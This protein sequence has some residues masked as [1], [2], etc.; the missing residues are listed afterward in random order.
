[1][2]DTSPSPEPTPP[3]KRGRTIAA[4]LAVILAAPLLLAAGWYYTR[5]SADQEALAEQAVHAEAAFAPTL[6]KLDEGITAAA[7]PDAPAYDIDKTIRVIHEIDQAV[8]NVDDLE[9]WLAQAS[10]QDYRGVAP[11][12]LEARRELL[13]VL[14]R[15]YA[16]QV[17]LDDQA[18][19]WDF[20]SGLV[21][22]SAMSVVEVEGDLNLMA[23]TGSLSVDQAKAEELLDK[24]LASQ[25]EQAR[26]Q[27]EL[28]AVEAELTRAMVQYSD[29][30][31]R[32]LEE[33][34][35]VNLAR[36]R[37]YLAAWSGSWDM[38]QEAS[39]EAI[40][41]AP[42]EREAHLLLA[43][44]LIEGGGG[45][46]D[47]EAERLLGDYLDA[48]PDASAPAL[49]L[50][51]V[52][53]ARAGDDERA[54]LN[55]EQSALSY[56]KQAAKLTDRLDP[57][58]T[59]TWLL[60]SAQGSHVLELYRS[61]MLGAGFFSP[62]LQ[63]AR[64]AF[65]EGDFDGGRA[66]VLEHFRRR[67]NQG[68]WDFIL[69]DLEFCHVLLGEDYTRIFPEDAWLDLVVGEAFIGDKLTVE[70]KNRSDVPL[71]N[72]SLVLALYLTDMF[73]G[74]YEA[75]AAGETRPVVAAG[76]VTDFGSVAVE[77]DG[78]YEGKG[79]DDN[80][81]ARAILVTDEA[82]VWVDS[83]A[84]KAKAL[85]SVQRASARPAAG[86]STGKAGQA[87]PQS[88]A[89]AVMAQL[90]EGTTLTVKDDLLS[91]DLRFQLPR[92]LTLLRPL[93]RLRHGGTLHEAEENFLV[94][95]HIELMF[96]DVGDLKGEGGAT[97]V[98]LVGRTPVGDM[99]MVW[100]IA[101][102]GMT[103]LTSVSL[104]GFTADF[105]E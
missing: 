84:F 40:A 99:V 8:G 18:A 89:D 70:V 50:L 77:F 96:E 95:D 92:G 10:R 5:W 61:T 23:P 2:S 97:D 45:E 26:L 63:L 38:A 56:P 9:A 52:L 71:H 28:R 48:H 101:P 20:S 98:T 1:M 75:I 102:G 47:R 79:P 74:D 58:R 15:V 29:V 69:S 54:R 11:E 27:K 13:D 21:M 31:Y 66:R 6:D 35:R 76:A 17:E 73:Q 57:Y 88:A 49:L 25:E 72:A 100:Q 33:W 4:I 59:R 80:I 32:Y 104:E 94:G 67:S 68:Q 24:L 82:V 36:E 34:D 64:T 39:R 83:E 86:T 16:R 53:H 51:G 81:D 43:L 3:K 105:S 41:L 103:Q 22:L 19:L 7:L 93:F 55:F 91:D 30:Y 60:R 37:A 42:L 65:E 62:D 44:S 78:F 46:R 12:V 87:W 85:Q 14:M 90:N